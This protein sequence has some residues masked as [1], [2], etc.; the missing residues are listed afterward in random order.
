MYLNKPG[1][2]CFLFIIILINKIIQDYYNLYGFEFHAP[3]MR[4]TKSISLRK[5]EHQCLPQIFSEHLLGDSHCATIWE[6][7]W[8]AKNDKALPAEFTVCCL[9]NFLL[10]R[11][12][13]FFSI[14]IT[15]HLEKKYYSGECQR[16][17]VPMILPSVL[18]TMLNHKLFNLTFIPFFQ[19]KIHGL[20]HG[21][22]QIREQ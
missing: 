18:D 2:L 16:S 1:V 13:F 6:Y 8:A 12:R 3:S 14:E 22:S 20:I 15:K 19:S 4:A 9:T 7:F 21:L 11:K 17:P 10:T 5:F